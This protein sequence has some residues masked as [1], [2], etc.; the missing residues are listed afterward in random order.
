MID[1][2]KG[3][4]HDNGLGDKLTD[5]LAQYEKNDEEHEGGSVFSLDLDAVKQIE[6]D[7]NQIKDK[8]AS[9]RKSNEFG[10]KSVL[11]ADSSRSNESS[12]RLSM[13]PSQSGPIKQFKK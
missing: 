3:L 6:S 2:L 1:S 12:G 8:P 4:A 11:N 13:R 7:E 5:I 10:R 9:G